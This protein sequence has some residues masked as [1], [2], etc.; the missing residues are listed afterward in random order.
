MRARQRAAQ[1]GTNPRSALCET[2]HT[3][4]LL[5]VDERLIR[6]TA[7]AMRDLGLVDAG[8]TYLNLDGTRPSQCIP[9]YRPAQTFLQCDLMHACITCIVCRWMV[10]A[11][12][13]CHTRAASAPT[14]VSIGHP[15]PRGVRSR[16]VLK[17]THKHTH[18]HRRIQTHTDTD[19]QSHTH[20]RIRTRTRAPDIT[21][22]CV[23]A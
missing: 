4:A 2:L 22:S 20:I 14:Q 16:Q 18:T 13:Q 11:H 6:F 8:Y 1:R 21:I 23:Q 5:A 15:R 7:N 9:P 12:T 3:P 10:S 17:H 19:T